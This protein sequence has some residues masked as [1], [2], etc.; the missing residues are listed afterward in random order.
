MAR[1]IP[2]KREIV[3]LLFSDV[4][5]YSSMTDAQL[6]VF[7]GKVLPDIAEIFEKH[8]KDFI[9]LNTWGD[10]IVIASRDPYILSHLALDLRDFFRDRNWIDDLLPAD[11]SCRIALH[12]GAVYVGYDPL[13]K[14]KGIVG[15]EVN[16]AARVEP[17]TSEGEVWVT[18]KFRPHINVDNDPTLAFQDLGEQPLAK[19][20]NATKL[21]RLSRSDEPKLDPR[22]FEVQKPASNEA[23][24]SETN[25]VASEPRRAGRPR[26]LRQPKKLKFLADERGISEVPAF[27]GNFTDVV[28]DV[29]HLAED[30]QGKEV[31]VLVAYRIGDIR[32]VLSKFRKR[33]GGKIRLCF[34]DMWDKALLRIHQRKYFD[35]TAEYIQNAVKDSIQ[36]ILGPCEFEHKKNG[37]L[38]RV[39]NNV[40]IPKQNFEVRLTRQ[41]LTYAF[42]RIDDIALIA[43][44]DMQ[45]DQRPAPLMWAFERDTAPETF[46]HYVDMFDAMFGEADS[47]FPW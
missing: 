38:L 41:R 17:V 2:I 28:N 14:R 25:R 24:I 33:P 27:V 26:T 37:R 15:S 18:D 20:F 43:P 47:V 12:C 40:S 8:R 45:T 31:D 10:A 44:L 23:V 42:Y 29:S 35:R 7:M 16:L 36:S 4:A 30:P 21:Y 39:I 6:E 9:E 34:P 32:R 13:R 11:L 46:Q 5:N 1:Q 19:Y 3:L 22:E